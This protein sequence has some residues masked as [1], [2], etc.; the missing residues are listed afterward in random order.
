MSHKVVNEVQ[1]VT[2]SDGHHTAT[3]SGHLCIGLVQ[4][5]MDIDKAVNDGLPVRWLGCQV[6]VCSREHV[7]CCVLQIRL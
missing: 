1:I 4:R 5:L 3:S 6:L 7:W 2:W